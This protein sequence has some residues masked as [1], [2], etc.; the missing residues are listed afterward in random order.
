MK[1]KKSNGPFAF[2]CFIRDGFRWE[3]LRLY[4]LNAMPRLRLMDVAAGLGDPKGRVPAGL[5]KV[6]FV[7]VGLELK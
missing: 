7:K 5:I 1:Y 6:M 2:G 4:N 3:K